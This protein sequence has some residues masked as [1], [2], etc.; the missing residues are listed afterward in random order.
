MVTRLLST[1]EVFPLPH[2][3]ANEQS[4][5]LTLIQTTLEVNSLSLN[6]IMVYHLSI[7]SDR[8]AASRP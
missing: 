3:T 2:L 6:H 1:L 5:L 4:H 7:L 8:R